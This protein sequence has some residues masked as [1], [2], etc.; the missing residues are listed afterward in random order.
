V[1][2]PV[3]LKDDLEQR[4][5]FMFK[6]HPVVD[7]SIAAIL[8]HVVHFLCHEAA[9]KLDHCIAK[10]EKSRLR[11]IALQTAVEMAGELKVI[12]LIV[13]L[14]HHL[15]KEVRPIQNTYRRFL[16]LEGASR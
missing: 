13:A 11:E 15:C 12:S 9:K 7:N 1:V 5:G 4:T 16:L 3:G 6:P 2:V 10:G 8:L 14:E